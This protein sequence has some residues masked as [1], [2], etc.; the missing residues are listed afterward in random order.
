[1]SL[2][3]LSSYATYSVYHVLTD[4]DALEI[5]LHQGLKEEYIQY[6]D[7]IVELFLNIKDRIKVEDLRVY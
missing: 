3:V 5:V 4:K 2:T 6:K 7:K 1:M